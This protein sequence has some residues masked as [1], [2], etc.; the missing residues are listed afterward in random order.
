MKLN[1]NIAFTYENVHYLSTTVDTDLSKD[2]VLDLQ[3]ELHDLFVDSEDSIDIDDSV[4]KETSIQEVFFDFMETRGSLQELKPE[5]EEKLKFIT[6][7][8]SNKK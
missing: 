2:E 7:K 4:D 8:F 6:D 3:G 1:I 5:M